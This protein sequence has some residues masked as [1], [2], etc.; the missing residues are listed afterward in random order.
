MVLSWD[1]HTPY[2]LNLTAGANSRHR[3]YGLP[4]FPCCNSSLSNSFLVRVGMHRYHRCRWLVARTFSWLFHYRPQ[5][6]ICW[7]WESLS[8]VLKLV[9]IVQPGWS[10]MEVE[11]KSWKLWKRWVCSGDFEELFPKLA[12]LPRTCY[13][14]MH[15]SI[16][17]GF[18]NKDIIS[19]WHS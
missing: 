12:L 1:H 8:L 7:L 3:T 11:M 9:R 18:A 6:G 16:Q 15:Q 2:L 14:A 17:I 4:I 5:R 10:K 19:A 13:F